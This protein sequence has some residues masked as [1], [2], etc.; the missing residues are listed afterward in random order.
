[1]AQIRNFL[2]LAHPP[3]T[4]VNKS[5]VR[6]DNEEEA[7]PL[8]SVAEETLRLLLLLLGMFTLIGDDFAFRESEKIG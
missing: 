8:A 2:L 7:S 4:M 3:H 5:I 6:F 1:M